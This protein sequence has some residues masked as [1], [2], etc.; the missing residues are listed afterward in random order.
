[1]AVVILPD[2]FEMFLVVWP[3]AGVSRLEMI[4]FPY[5]YLVGSVLK[6]LR[7]K[8]EARRSGACGLPMGLASPKEPPPAVTF[9]VS[10][11]S[12]SLLLNCTG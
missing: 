12:F 5:L 8:F 2:Y 10:Q 1:M 11:S 6:P 4:C 9:R 7:V 3:Q